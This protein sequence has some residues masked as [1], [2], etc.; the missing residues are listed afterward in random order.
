[1]FIEE[2]KICTRNG[3]EEYAKGLSRCIAQKE[4]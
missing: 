3:E 2:I 4:L 1:M